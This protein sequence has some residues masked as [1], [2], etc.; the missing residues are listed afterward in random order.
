MCLGR[1]N[2][3][4]RLLSGA[5][6]AIVEDRKI[7]S[8]KIVLFLR[9][10]GHSQSH[11]RKIYFIFVLLDIYFCSVA[12]RSRSRIS[13]SNSNGHYWQIIGRVWRNNLEITKKNLTLSLRTE[14]QSVIAISRFTSLPHTYSY[15]LCVIQ[16]RNSRSRNRVS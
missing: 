11:C 9:K 13:F 10:W 14:Q 12:L 7:I 2:R 16:T 3:I 15:V 8:K 6:K 4:A 1:M 5:L